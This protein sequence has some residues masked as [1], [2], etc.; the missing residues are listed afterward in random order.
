MDSAW[1]PQDHPHPTPQLVRHYIYFGYRTDP[2]C[3]LGKS[4]KCVTPAIGLSPYRP[5]YARPAALPLAWWTRL[6]RERGTATQD[7]VDAGTRQRQRAATS[8][9]P[10]LRM[11]PRGGRAAPRCL[12]QAAFRMCC[13]WAVVKVSV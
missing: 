12:A 11:L 3:Q 6:V 1:R 8:P 2:L 7:A 5:L 4:Y 13:C 10:G 9:A